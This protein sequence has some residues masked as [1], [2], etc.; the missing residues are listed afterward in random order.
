MATTD[1]D[2]D[3]T[4]RFNITAI[5]GRTITVNTPFRFRHFGRVVSYDGYSLDMRAEVAVLTSNVVIEVKRIGDLMHPRVI[6]WIVF[7]IKS[8]STPENKW[9]MEGTLS[10]SMNPL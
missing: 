6:W 4:E 2:I 10:L 8:P 9:L 7:H 1:Y 3:Q 5:N